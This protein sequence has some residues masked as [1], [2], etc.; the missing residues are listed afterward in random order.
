MQRLRPQSGLWLWLHARYFKQAL[1]KLQHLPCLPQRPA[2]QHLPPP[3]IVRNMYRTHT[4]RLHFGETRNG[5]HCV[6]PP[7]GYSSNPMAC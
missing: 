2:Q 4:R 3:P 5:R 1:H 7:H 6:F